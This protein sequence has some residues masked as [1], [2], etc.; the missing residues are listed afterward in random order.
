MVHVCIYVCMYVHIYCLRDVQGEA[1][2]GLPKVVL[3]RHQ[4]FAFLHQTTSPHQHHAVR[5]CF[6]FPGAC[7]SELSRPLCFWP[8][9]Y[10]PSCQLQEEQ[11][12][13]QDQLHPSAQ[14]WIQ[15]KPDLIHDQPPC[16]VFL[17]RA[18]PLVW[19]LLDHA[20]PLV[21]PIEEHFH[22]DILNL[23]LIRFILI[24]GK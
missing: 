15:V 12:R 16:F 21:W 17:V 10:G 11:R 23:V 18:Q 2:P 14:R 24:R 7:L 13:A 1:L 6:S 22:K 19:P 4:F 20:Q 8:L 3:L 5:S 9:L